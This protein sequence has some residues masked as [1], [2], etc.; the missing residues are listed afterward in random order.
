MLGRDPESAPRASSQFAAKAAAGNAHATGGRADHA[1]LLCAVTLLVA[2]V[3]LVTFVGVGLWEP[4][5]V[6]AAELARRIAIHLL[7]ARD[8]IVPGAVNE[9]PIRRELGRGELPFT[10]IALGFKLFGLSDWAARLPLALWALVGAAATFGLVAR[11]ANPRAA[12]LSTLVLCVTPLY[13]V[14]ARLL[15]GESVTM[16][17]FALAL[18]G[19]GVALLDLRLTLWQRAPWLLG[20]ALGLLAGFWCRGLLLGVAVPLVAVCI[21]RLA[22]HERSEASRPGRWLDPGLVVATALVVALGLR[23]LFAYQAG[24]AYSIW[25]GSSRAIVEARPTHDAVIHAL[26]HALFPM[27]ALLPFAF[28]YLLTPVDRARRGEQHLRQLTAGGLVAGC[29][30]H[31]VL[32]PV[33]G[34]LP[35]VATPACAVAIGLMLTDLTRRRRASRVVALGAV[36]LLVLL[37]FDLRAR[38]ESAFAAFGGTGS[39]FPVALVTMHQHFWLAGTLL[40]LVT[41]SFAVQEAT[42]TR[43]DAL[44]AFGAIGDFRAYLAALRAAYAGNLWFGLVA[45]WLLLVTWFG[46]LVIGEGVLSLS[47]FRGWWSLARTALLHAWWVLAALVVLAP[48]AVFCVRH[49]VNWLDRASRRRAGLLV[50]PSRTGVA[51]TGLVASGLL[52]SLVYYPRLAAE[53]SPKRVFE[54]YRAR[55]N[56]GEPLGLL[57]VSSSVAAYY[58]GGSPEWLPTP[59]EAARWLE[60]KEQRRFLLVRAS[61]L[62]E[63]NAMHR[64]LT[65]P[66]LNLPVLG[67]GPSEMLLASNRL[68]G[69]PNSNPLESMVRSRA[70]RVAHPVDAN[71]AGRLE[72]V[73]WQLRTEG[74]AFA[75]VV[76]PGR[77]F[78]LELVYRVVG[79]FVDEWETFVHIDGS[80]RRFNAD[81]ETLRGEYP[82]RWW[83]KGDIIVDEHAITLDPNFTP[84]D[85]RLYFGMYRGQR[86]LPVQRGRHDDDRVD[87]GVIEVR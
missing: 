16:A 25:V 73:G 12:C 49:A 47:V 40:V 37:F 17:A 78:R 30:A 26:G 41:F 42:H 71:L 65:R 52:L 59:L 51:T 23:A 35:F 18:G 66:A 44:P 29:F 11:L 75:N 3:S 2:V 56:A 10:S 57:G 24:G 61:D 43:R 80:G 55:A 27:S 82:M 9:I 6:D 38:P 63:L 13:F 33:T 15:S 14:Q 83:T 74:G 58:T 85:Y 60:A 76:L 84:G 22:S 28:A 86:R 48:L 79:P 77:K 8:L 31:A 54:A 32:A 53:F 62:P 68:G 20:G 4:L 34:T 39:T 5:E 7:G 87:G 64:R 70:P 72:V 19:V 50:F 81:H 69:E 1:R 21:A 67:V 46:A 36:A 45:C